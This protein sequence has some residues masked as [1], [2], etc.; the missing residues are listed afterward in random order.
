MACK[1]I[2]TNEFK[3]V[4]ELMTFMLRVTLNSWMSINIYNGNVSGPF[5]LK[6][7]RYS[8]KGPLAGNFRIDILSEISWPN[9]KLYYV[10]AKTKP[11]TPRPLLFC[12]N[13]LISI[14]IYNGH[15]V[16]KLRNTYI[17]L[18][19]IIMS[20]SFRILY[21]RSVSLNPRVRRT[22]RNIHREWL[23][24]ATH[25]A[26]WL[27]TARKIQVDGVDFTVLFS[28]VSHDTDVVHASR[29]GNLL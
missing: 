25:T 18:W 22:T 9:H 28:M 20:L 11:V 23:I 1:I 17:K 29:K 21:A 19:L 8:M 4:L 10:Y 24:L 16:S 5:S 12:F 14:R 15:V 13:Y 2:K 26:P 7:D 3:H 6:Y 27:I